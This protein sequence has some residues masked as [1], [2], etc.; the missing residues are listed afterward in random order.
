MIL[1]LLLSTPK[2]SSRSNDFTKLASST[3]PTPPPPAASYLKPQS[4]LISWPILSH[5]YFSS[6]STKVDPFDLGSRE[7]QV[8]R[9]TTLISYI[10]YQFSSFE[11]ILF[12]TT[13]T[14][15]WRLLSP[16]RYFYFFYFCFR[17]SHEMDL[18]FILSSKPL[19]HPT[20]FS[21]PIPSG[22]VS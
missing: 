19:S 7:D 5:L 20:F 8:T 2:F 4:P 9:T 13:T 6:P 17:F 11:V 15:Q 14:I 18:N 12:W 22:P 21:G 3:G 10:G 1:T 16:R